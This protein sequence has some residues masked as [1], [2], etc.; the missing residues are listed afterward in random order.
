[1]A[2]GSLLGVYYGSK[3]SSKLPDSLLKVIV[4]ILISIA[5]VMMLSNYLG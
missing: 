4:I 2:A 1:M 3:L 5:A